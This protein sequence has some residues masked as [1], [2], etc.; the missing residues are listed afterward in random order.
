MNDPEVVPPSNRSSES[1]PRRR[2]VE[3]IMG[4]GFLATAAAFVYPI[5]RYLVPPKDL[6]S[7][8]RGS[9]WRHSDPLLWVSRCSITRISKCL[10]IGAGQS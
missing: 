3:V 10:Q 4:S 9:H 6:S 2:F 7:G 1:L 5:L 8:R